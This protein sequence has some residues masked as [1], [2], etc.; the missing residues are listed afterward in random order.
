MGAGIER[1]QGDRSAQR[2]EVC[3]SGSG[4]YIDRN[5][6]AAVKHVIE[7]YGV[8]TVEIGAGPDIVRGNVEFD[9][10]LGSKEKLVSKLGRERGRGVDAVAKGDDHGA[11]ARAAGATIGNELAG[12]LGGVGSVA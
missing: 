1:A 12:C 11:V 10:R 8:A 5:R 2:D 9:I 7:R 3:L 4:L 6:G